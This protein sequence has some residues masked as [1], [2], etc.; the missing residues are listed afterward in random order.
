LP[1][2]VKLAAQSLAFS[3]MLCPAS[4]P[5]LAASP[6]GVSTKDEAIAEQFAVAIDSGNAQDPQSPNTLNTRL[7]FAEFLA[8]SEGGD[9]RMRLENAQNQL[10][11]ARAS[12]AGVALPFALAREAAIE[13]QIHVG[14]ANCGNSAVLREQELRAAVESARHAVDLYRDDFDAISMVTMQFNVGVAYHELGQDTPA[15][16]ALQAAIKMDREYGFREDA[17][18]NYQILLQWNGQPAGNDEVAALMKDFPQR[19]ATLSFGWFESKAD[20]TLTLEYE[21][22]SAGGMLKMQGM[23]AAER[24]VR[25]SRNDW[26]VSF[27]PRGTH[28]EITNWPNDESL[29]RGIVASLPRIAL[30]F[31][32]FNV[33]RT[34]D[35]T[36]STA[37]DKFGSGMRSDVKAVTEFLTQSNASSPLTDQIREES[38]KYGNSQYGTSVETLVAET[39]NIE[40][41]TWIGA[42][43]EQGV[44]YEMNVPLSLLLAPGLFVTHQIEFAFTRR[45]PCMAGSIGEACMEII[46]RAT[47]D[48]E[49]LKI[50]LVNLSQMMKLS[51]NAVLGEKVDLQL[52][53]ATYMRLVTD[54]TTLQFFESDMRRY[55]YWTNTGTKFDYPVMVYERTHAVSG[56][57]TRME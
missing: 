45:V 46:V 9:C 8:K 32:N 29:V 25:R 48:P 17:K 43:L 49:E 57:I 6:T 20:L 11:M 1:P 40:T 18:D 53:S 39:Y 15:V 33:G 36:Q 7:G 5:L 27:E 54:P 23:K 34:G 3:A 41:G 47:P 12:Q 22:L 51:Q 21:Q 44:W 28:Y 42:S 4:M 14:R 56:P 26:T 38:G 37:A 2:S 52:S 16:T 30:Q 13:Y 19:S 35:F 31:H 24:R 50:R 10:D 55:G